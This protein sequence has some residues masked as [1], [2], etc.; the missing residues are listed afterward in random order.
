MRLNNIN[1]LIFEKENE[2][3]AVIEDINV[4][5]QRLRALTKSINKK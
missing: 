5:T 4:L 1:T 2:K 3:Q